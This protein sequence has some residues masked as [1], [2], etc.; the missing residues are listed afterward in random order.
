MLIEFS[1]GLIFWMTVSFLT[2]LFIL[3]KFAWKPILGALSERERTIEDAL[4][5]AKKAREE[6]AAMSSRN[7]ELMR[8]AREEREVL[9]K[10]ARDIRDK[11]IAEARSRAKVEADAILSR[12]RID[13]QNEK[14]A[15]ITEMKNQV[16]ELSIL[17]AERILKDK[18]SENAAQQSLVDKVMTEAELRKS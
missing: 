16:A 14:M 18:L 1:F 11:E 12:A 13:I 10:E 15:A 4:N 17:V 2:V 9:L 7:E 5:E 3:K 6:I 8:D